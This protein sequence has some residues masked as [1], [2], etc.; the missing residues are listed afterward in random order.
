MTK[1]DYRFLA[2][3]AQRVGG[4]GRQRL[5][6]SSLVSRQSSLVQSLALCNLLG[7]IWHMIGGG[8][9]AKRYHSINPCN[10]VQNRA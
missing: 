9:E 8:E 4:M 10:L 6:V 1:S 3:L 5:S 2:M 7:A